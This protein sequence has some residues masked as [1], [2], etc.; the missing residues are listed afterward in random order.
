VNR[1]ASSRPTHRRAG[2]AGGLA[3]KE[4]VAMVAYMQRLGT[5]DLNAAPSRRR[6]SGPAG[7]RWRSHEALRHHG[8]ERR[9]AVASTP[10]VALV[11]FLWP[12]WR[13]WSVFAPGQ[14]RE[15]ARA[16][17]LPSMTTTRPAPR[18]AGVTD[19]QP[20]K[21]RGSPPRARVRRHPGVRQSDAALVAAGSST[22]RSS[23]V[24]FYYVPGAIGIGQG[25]RGRLRGRRWPR[26]GPRIRRRPAAL[27]PSSCARCG[28]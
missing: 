22:P 11:L 23:I 15:F 10:I 3:D 19:G 26:R 6:Q 1:P 20:D 18:S 7:G 24:P 8:H 27:G 28:P 25:A 4:I 17:R 16:A 21:E 5:S 14:A 13:S 9:R 2:W 12:S